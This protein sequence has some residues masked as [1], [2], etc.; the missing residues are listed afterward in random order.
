MSLRRHGAIVALLL[1]SACAGKEPVDTDPT[2]ASLEKRATRLQPAALPVVTLDD[3]QKTYE[4]LARSTENPELKAIALERLADIGL[5]KA[6]AAISGEAGGAASQPAPAVAAV[7]S[8]SPAPAQGE[9]LGKSI[10]QYQELLALYP[11]YPGNDRVLYQL[12]WAHELNGELEATLDTLT[13]L[14]ERYPQT[15]NRDEVQFRRGEILFTFRDYEQAEL[16]Y[17]DVIQLGPESTYF[18]RSHFKH[19]WSVFK[20]GDTRR[21]LDSYFAVLDQYFAGGRDVGDFSRSE[22]ELLDD[23]LRIVSLSFAY[24][25]GSES[26]TAFFNEYGA[27]DYEHRIYHQLSDLYMTQGRLDDAVETLMVFIRRHPQHAQSALLTVRVIEL[28]EQGKRPQELLLAKADLVTYY[29]IG[30]AFWDD[31]DAALLEQLRPHLKKNTDDLSSHYHAQAQQ[32]KKPADYRLAA[33]WYRVYVNAFPEDPETPQRNFLLAETLED[34]GDT[35]AAAQEFEMTAYQYLPHARS[36]EAGYAAILAHQ[37]QIATL[38]GEARDRKRLE[39]IQSSQRFIAAFP[40]D[41]RVISVTSNTAEELFELK[42]YAQAVALST[43]LVNHQPPPE[44]KLLLINWGI[45]AQGEFESAHFAASERASLQR[46]ALLPVDDKSRNNDIE[47]LAAA[48]YKQGEAARDAGQLSLAAEHFL[49]VGRLAPTATIRANAEYDAATSYHA[50]RQWDKAIPILKAFVTTY[51]QH[52]LRRGAD[53]KLA[54]AYEQSGDW[55]ATAAAYEVLY[56]HETDPEKKRLLLWQSAE[57]Y[58]KAGQPQQ[59]LDIYKRYVSDYPQPYDAAIEARFRLASIYQ[60]R[61]D[62]GSRHYWLEQIIKA[63]KKGPSTER[64]RYLAATGALEL[65]EPGYEAFRRVQLTQPLK[66]NLQKKKTL[67]ED[68]I[69]AYT[70]AAEYGVETVTTTST[71]RIGEIY[72]QFSRSLYDSERP[73]GLNEEELEQYEILLEEQA[74][75]F[76]EKAIEIHAVNARRASTGVYDEWVRKSFAALGKLSPVRYAKSEMHEDIHEALE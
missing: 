32:S 36:A 44:T 24:L 47:R 34:A 5:D 10:A 53:E 74:F 17:Q 48:I 14:L 2:L 45:I 68:S 56:R 75:P 58:Q 19:G 27:R 70:Q 69:K 21:A 50:A 62:S 67:M 11:D 37:R 25:K 51:P 16:A 35:V 4:A 33:Q 54:I 15:Q 65:A 26:I 23:T 60:T 71:Y 42:Q 7:Q 41:A 9:H 12:A 63:D 1:L 20:Q 57:F 13:E 43:R 46:L 38:K 29:G 66:T 30:S 31:K 49:R 52:A 55:G 22:Q 39:A 72:Q 28:F 76:E 61:G 73:A 64:S 18:Q 59:A 8:P 40:D 6:Q 3:I